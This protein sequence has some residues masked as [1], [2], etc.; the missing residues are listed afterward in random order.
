M[1]RVDRTSW[2]DLSLGRFKRG[3]IGLPIDT[4]LDYKAQICAQV[5]IPTKDRDGN[6]MTKYETPGNRADHFGHARNYAEIA[7]PFALGVGTNTDI[8]E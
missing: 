5:R 1:I 3:D 6:P 7:L 4:S 8:R 2:L